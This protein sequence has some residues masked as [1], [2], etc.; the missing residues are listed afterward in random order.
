MIT[1]PEM[2]A[3]QT[4]FLEVTRAAGINILASYFCIHAPDDECHCR[5]PS[6]FHV[7]MA[8]REYGLDLSQSWMMG[9]RRSDIICGRNA[10]CKSI[11]LENPGFP[12][13]DGL[14]DFVARD[15]DAACRIIRKNAR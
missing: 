2:A 15:W 11:W 7:V 4:R 6:A 8:A 3:V 10:G 12:V 14:A 5:K 1:P 9:D 13:V